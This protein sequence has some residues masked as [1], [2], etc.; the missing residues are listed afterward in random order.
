MALISQSIPNLINGVSQQPPSLRLNTQ[1][2]LQEN[3]LSSVVNG[4]S[5]RPSSDHI[6]DLGVISNT[7]KAFIHTIRRDETEFYSL[8]VDTA[9]TIKVFDKDGTS[10]TVTNNAS[11]YLTG[12]TD[13]SKELAAVSIADNTFI[14]N[15]NT[16]VAKGTTTSS[17]RNPEALVYVKQADYSSTYRLKVTKGANT[18]TVEFATKSS[19]QSS[20]ALTQDAER[21]A[22]TD[23]IAENLNT[24][25]AQ[26]LVLLL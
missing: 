9:G 19:T 22:S 20:T 10:K 1:A 11:S 21:G 18:D 25:L 17:T 15:K 13:P 26:Q 23:L 5:K 7:D 16:E 3:G 8:V 4:L 2:E 6:A 12:L 14:I 24:F